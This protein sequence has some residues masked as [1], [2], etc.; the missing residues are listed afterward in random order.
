MTRKRTHRKY[1]P[2]LH[3][4]D[5]ITACQPFPEADI[6]RI[7]L[8]VDAALE[9]LSSGGTNIDHFD[10]MAAVLNVGLI[11]C[12]QIGEEG[13]VIFKAAQAALMEC[14]ALYGR[15]KKFG[16]TGPG[17]EAIKDAISLYEQI[18]RASTPRQMDDAQRECMARVRR[19]EYEQAQAATQVA[20]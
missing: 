18:L 9:H 4:L 15:H 3:P 20:A 11:R 8:K 16:F 5:A 10:R 7:L 6:A 17:L 14:D 2:G 19:G 13:V 12:E 1:K